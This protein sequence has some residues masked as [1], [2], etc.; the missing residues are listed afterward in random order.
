VSVN[1]IAC[2]PK[3]IEGPEREAAGW[4]APLGSSTRAPSADQRVPVEPSLWWRANVKRA[5][6]GPPALGERV[7]AVATVDRALTLLEW[8]TGETVWRRNLGAPATGAPLL[9]GDRVYVATTARQGRVH[10]FGLR[11][12]NRAWEARVGPLVPPLAVSPGAVYVGTERGVVQALDAARGGRRWTRRLG[13]VLRCGPVDVGDA[14]FV[15]T[16]DSLFLLAQRDGAVLARRAAPATVIA[17]PAWRD[18]TL[19]IA[20]PDGVIA[21]LARADLATLWT[22]PT[23]H[24]DPVFGGPALARDT[25]FAITLGGTLW[26][27]PL[28]APD[29]AVRVPLGVTVRAPAAPTADGVLIG[30]T[31][32]EVLLVR[33]D[34]AER[35]ARVDGP[36]EQ[37]PIVKDGV[38]LVIDGKGRVM[39]WR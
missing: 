22:V 36:V 38:L 5:A 19:V 33:G 30:T 18:D 7:L 27:I 15:A 21:G 29:Q 4:S 1:A 28:A 2:A 39:T 25:A 12:G 16:D 3:V 34:S 23:D 32:G 37:P 13:G 8:D 17:P 10:A 9:V 31:A 11:R 14:L 35:R 24:G 26:R 20:S 6:A